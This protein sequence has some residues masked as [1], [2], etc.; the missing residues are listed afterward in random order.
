MK[1]KIVAVFTKET[2]RW[3][4]K[5]NNYVDRKTTSEER[6]IEVEIFTPADGKLRIKFI[7]GPTG[8]E[9]YYADD[10]SLT[11]GRTFCICGGTINSWSRCTVLSDDVIKFLEDYK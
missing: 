10:L 2:G 8:F 11:P 4:S 5:S 9:Q 7:G 1:R 6:L 3:D